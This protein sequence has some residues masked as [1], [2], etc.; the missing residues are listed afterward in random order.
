M[1]FIAGVK[2]HNKSFI[3][4]LEYGTYMT[5]IDD[6]AQ[7]DPRTLASE[8]LET[9]LQSSRQIRWR[10]IKRKERLFVVLTTKIYLRSFLTLSNRIVLV[11]E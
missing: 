1:Q 8:R 11:D 4:T 6:I 7:F 9:I 10:N 2:R 3:L 5:V